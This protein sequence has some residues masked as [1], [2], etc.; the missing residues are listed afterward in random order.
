[1]A[2]WYAVMQNNQDTD[3][4]YGS[5]DLAVAKAMAQNIGGDAYIVVVDDGD[6]PIA[7]DE[8]RDLEISDEEI[9]GI[10]ENLVAGE[11]D[12]EDRD[13][14]QSKFYFSDEDIDRILAVMAEIR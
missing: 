11:L 3:W 6:D 14:I 7:V 13:I 8:I 1:M 12:P 5:K 2:L 10:A 4:G 9:R